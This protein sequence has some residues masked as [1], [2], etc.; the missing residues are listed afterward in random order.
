[1]VDK[2][3]EKVY[4]E[5]FGNIR[6]TY[7]DVKKVDPSIKYDDVKRWFEKNQVRKMNLAGY[8]SSIARYPRQEYQIDLFFLNY[9]NADE[10]KIA[11]L[12]IDIFQSSWK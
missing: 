8:N 2:T 1:M 11:M 9:D 6:D 3:I 4:N 5:F 10:Y 12:L 7:N